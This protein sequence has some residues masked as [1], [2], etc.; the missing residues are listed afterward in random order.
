MTATP[1][2]TV[3]KG[4]PTEDELAGS[5]AEALARILTYCDPFDAPAV[6]GASATVVVA[7]RLGTISPWASKAT[8]IVR[9]CGFDLHRVERGLL[10]QEPP[11]RDHAGQPQARRSPQ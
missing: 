1:L 5:D 2:F 4:N 10:G 9:N 11:R 7:P 6:T 8:D 3:T